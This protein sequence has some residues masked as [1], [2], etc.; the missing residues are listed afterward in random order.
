M[1]CGKVLSSKA[2]QHIRIVM[3]AETKI[4]TISDHMSKA[5]KDNYVY[6]EELSLILSGLRKFNQMKDEIRTKSKSKI[7]D[8][9]KL[10]LIKQDK[11]QAVEQFR[12]MLG[13]CT[14]ERNEK[15]TGKRN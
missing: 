10:S 13:N 12:S 1:I 6:N 5:A 4:S 15:R 8:K 11:E 14:D 7:D 9:T 3:L 2:T